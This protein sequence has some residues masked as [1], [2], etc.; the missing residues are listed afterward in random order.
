MA[1]KTLRQSITDLLLTQELTVSGLA[2]ALDV[3]FSE[4]ESALEH[5][6]K[7]IRPKKIKS[8]PALCQQ[9]G[10]VFRERKKY[11]RPSRC[12]ECRSEWI[13]EASFTIH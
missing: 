2:Q 11:S 3:K 7:S 4:I 9:C 1:D 12:P 8:R 5:I 13:K 6:E 10:F